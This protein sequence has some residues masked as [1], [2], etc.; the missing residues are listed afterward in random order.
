M[1]LRRGP[2]LIAAGLDETGQTCRRELDGLFVDLFSPTLN[3]SR[4]I[5]VC[6][7]NRMLWL[8]IKKIKRDAPTV[9]AS[10]SKIEDEKTSAGALEFHSEGPSETTCATRVLLPSQPKSVK[11]GEYAADK[12]KQDWDAESKTLLLR[13]PNS[14]EGLKV[15]ISY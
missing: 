6:P 9:L 3:V 7:G 12:I 8:D 10:A 15:Q 5:T 14:A 13:Y 11:V 2:Y 4:K 1:I